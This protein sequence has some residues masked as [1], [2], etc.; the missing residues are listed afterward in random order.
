MQRIQILPRF[1]VAVV[2]ALLAVVARA[3]D[4]RPVSQGDWNAP[5]FSFHT[6]ETLANLRLHYRTL[7]NPQ[8]EPVLVL[9]GTGQSGAAMLT[10]AFAGDLFG[11][12]QPL[13]AAK[14]F[15][16]L[17]DALGAGQSARPSD[18]LRAAFPHYN[19]DDMVLVQYRLLTEGLGI[20]HVRLIIGN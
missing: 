12:G 17:P 3:A 11:P 15:I 1:V 20:R 14:Y 7:G 16:I 10:P 19:Y 18:G 9:H 4:L 6:G 2:I 8:D 13:D 5:S